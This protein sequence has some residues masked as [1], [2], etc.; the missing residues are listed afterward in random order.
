MAGTQTTSLNRTW[1]IKMLAIA[2]LFIGF[3][4]WGYIDA[5]YVYPQRGIRAADY[6]KWEYLQEAKR[7]NEGGQSAPWSNPSIADPVAAF[8]QLR[9]TAPENLKP[10]DA[11]KKAWLESLTIVGRL[12]PEY[13]AVGNPT[14]ELETLRQEFTGPNGQPRVP[15]TLS[16]YDIPVQWVI[17][18]VGLL[19]GLWMLGLV[20]LVSRV[21]YTYDSATKTLGL[22]DGSTLSVGECEDFDRR[23]WDKFLMFVK[24][25]PG[26]ARHGGKELRF[27][28]LRHVPLEEWIVEMEY[29][30]FPDRAKSAAG[31]EPAPASEGASPAV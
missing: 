8:D 14:D 31:E 2:V 21:K 22:P 19:V 30:A 18:A 1:T 23:K 11:K 26:H 24:V 3:G 20:G 4:I 25:K 17:F 5:V 13:T 27:D 6:L 28:L 29:T 7:A 16:W 12:T 9:K 10:V 15:K